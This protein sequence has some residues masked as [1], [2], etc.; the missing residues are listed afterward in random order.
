M[1]NARNAAYSSYD[2]AD[3][4]KSKHLPLD[5]E[6]SANQNEEIGKLFSK[7]V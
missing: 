6:K 3:I 7:I 1:G 2:E 4:H 5:G